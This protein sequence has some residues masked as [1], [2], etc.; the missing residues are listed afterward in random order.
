MGASSTP[1]RPRLTPRRTR[2]GRRVCR[3]GRRATRGRKTKTRPGRAGGCVAR[4]ILNFEFLVSRRQRSSAT[5]RWYRAGRNTPLSRTFSNALGLERSTF[6]AHR[7]DKGARERPARLESFESSRWTHDGTSRAR[8]LAAA[9]SPARAPA[10]PSVDRSL[11]RVFFRRHELSHHVLRLGLA[12]LDSARIARSLR[13][14]GPD[15]GPRATFH[16]ARAIP[17][18]AR[19]RYRSPRS[20]HYARRARAAPRV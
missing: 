5:D 20:R 18:A 2:R 19:A 16:R 9:L 8:P 7:A 17:L 13:P 11:M 14:R 15:A 4:E 1:S 12:A 6:G 10:R 3:G